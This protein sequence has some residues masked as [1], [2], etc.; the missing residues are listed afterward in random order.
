MLTTVLGE[1]HDGDQ[2]QFLNKGDSTVYEK[3]AGCN[4]RPPGEASWERT[5]ANAVVRLVKTAAQARAEE[6]QS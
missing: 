5:S 1:L 2:F 6:E 4:Y 3:F